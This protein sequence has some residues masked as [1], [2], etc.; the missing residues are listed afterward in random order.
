MHLLNQSPALLLWQ[1]LGANVLTN[2]LPELCVTWAMSYVS[3]DIFGNIYIS[4]WMSCK[5]LASWGNSI[6]Y[7]NASP[8]LPVSSSCRTWAP[9]RR[10]V[11]C[12]SPHRSLAWAGSPRC[13][14]E[15]PS[16][17]RWTGPQSRRCPHDSWANAWIPLPAH[18]PPPQYTASATAPE[19]SVRLKHC[20]K[21]P[22]RMEACSEYLT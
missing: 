6:L 10:W 12:G 1:N 3:S 13:G 9:A 19:T 15:W 17:S 21:L 20:I 8:I 4:P 7:L 11:R 5:N 22:V 18:S 16:W 2:V 14:S